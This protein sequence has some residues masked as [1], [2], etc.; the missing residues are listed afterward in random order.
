MKEFIKSL[1]KFAIGVF[2]VLLL[3]IY[4]AKLVIDRSDDGSTT[5]EL[6]SLKKEV[7]DLKKGQAEIK[8][9]LD[10]ISTM[11]TDF[12]SDLDTLK[13]GQEIIYNQVKKTAEKSFFD[14]F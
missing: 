9:K 1:F 12:K 13:A 6:D 3:G 14:W 8:A 2:V 7:L 4:I 11:Q 5:R 10:T